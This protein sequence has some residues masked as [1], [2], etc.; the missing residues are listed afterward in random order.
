MDRRPDIGYRNDHALGEMREFQTFREDAR[1]IAKAAEAFASS[2]SM[3][4]FF[5]NMLDEGLE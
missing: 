4:D 3:I 2:I 1:K 5:V